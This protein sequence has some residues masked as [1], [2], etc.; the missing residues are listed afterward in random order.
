MV[1]LTQGH[2]NL[3]IHNYDIIIIIIIIFIIFIIIIIVM[4][5]GPQYRS[6]SLFIYIYYLGATGPSSDY[7]SISKHVSNNLQWV[8][9]MS[10]ISKTNEVV[11]IALTGWSR[12]V[13]FVFLH[14]KLQV[15]HRFLFIRKSILHVL[16]LAHF[17]IKRLLPRAF[18]VGCDSLV[19][20]GF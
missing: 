20:W 9:I 10:K 8:D 5:D 16:Y 15:N 1:P 4:V 17:R 7:V 2:P 14:L 3:I 19:S 11:G 13:S 18:A 6:S 12:R